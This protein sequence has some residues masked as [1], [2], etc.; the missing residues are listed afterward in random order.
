M[1]TLPSTAP[2]TRCRVVHPYVNTLYEELGNCD[3]VVRNEHD[4]TDE[5]WLLRD[6]HDHLDE[7]LTC[8]VCRVSLTCE[9]ELYR[10]LRIVY[11]LCK[12]V[13]VTEKEVSSLICSETTC[14][15][16]REDVIAKVLLDCND[17]L[18]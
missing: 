13:E 3:V 2:A 11:D 1:S 17:L 18:R 4:L 8:L 12:S 14:E 6:L 15:T 7:V 16:D 9:E 5:A 10:L